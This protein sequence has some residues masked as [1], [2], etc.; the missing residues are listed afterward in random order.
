MKTK[1]ERQEHF[2]Y[3]IIKSGFRILG[4]CIAFTNIETVWAWQIFIGCFFVAEIL[5]IV[6]EL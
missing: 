4:C 1:D 6:E 3:S 2:A 5:G